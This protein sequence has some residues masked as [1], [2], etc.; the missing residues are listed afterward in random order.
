MFIFNERDGYKILIPI[1]AIYMKDMAIEV[2]GIPILAIYPHVH[3]RELDSYKD[4]LNMN[5]DVHI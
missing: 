4:P 5:K 2:H 3:I 1:Y